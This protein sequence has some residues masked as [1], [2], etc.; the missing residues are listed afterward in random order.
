VR[1]PSGSSLDPDSLR[2]QHEVD[3]L[4]RRWAAGDEREYWRRWKQLGSWSINRTQ[5]DVVKK[6]ALK[7]KLMEKTGARCEDCGNPFE[8]AALQM[9]RLDVGLAHDPQHN[10]GYIEENV[11]LLCAVC[12]ERWEAERR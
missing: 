9:H 10:F 1:P 12:H 11:R 2:F 3:E 7:K 5:G 4:V 6:S 8:A